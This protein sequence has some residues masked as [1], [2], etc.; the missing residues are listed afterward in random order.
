MSENTSESVLRSIFLPTISF[1]LFLACT[2]TNVEGSNCYQSQFHT[3]RYSLQQHCTSKQNA[4]D[5]KL[6]NRNVFFFTVLGTSSSRSWCQ[7]WALFPWAC[8]WL[9]LWYLFHMGIPLSTQN[10]GVSLGVFKF[11]LIRTP[12]RLESPYMIFINHKYLFKSSISMYSHS[13]ISRG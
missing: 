8:Q 3:F 9:P 5:G 12:G 6:T 13:L 4:T 2:S 11:Y 7:R 10:P 1:V